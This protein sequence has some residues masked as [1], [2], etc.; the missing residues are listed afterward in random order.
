MFSQQIKQEQQSSSESRQAPAQRRKSSA[1]ALQDNR[2][3]SSQSSPVQRQPNKT[4]LPDNLKSG[5]AVNDNPS[6]EKEADDMGVKAM[7]MKELQ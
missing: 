4:G 1:T 6:L 2:S 7:Q 5:M 3:L